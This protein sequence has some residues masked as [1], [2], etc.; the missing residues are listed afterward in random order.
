MGEVSSPGLCEKALTHKHSWALPMAGGGAICL[1]SVGGKG[2]Y[3]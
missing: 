2:V 1:V 3:S